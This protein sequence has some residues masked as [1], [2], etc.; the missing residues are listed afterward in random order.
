MSDNTPPIDYPEVLE[1]IGVIEV[2]RKDEEDE[3]VENFNDLAVDSRED[4]PGTDRETHQRVTGT[5]GTTRHEISVSGLLDEVLEAVYFRGNSST[6]DL[7]R[8]V[9]YGVIDQEGFE[10]KLQE[11]RDDDIDYIG[12]QYQSAGEVLIEEIV[13]TLSDL[14]ADELEVGIFTK[15]RESWNTGRLSL[16]HPSFW[17]FDFSESSLDSLEDF[18]NEDDLFWYGIDDIHVSNL[19]EEIQQYGD[20]ERYVFPG[21]RKFESSVGSFRFRSILTNFHSEGTGSR[22]S[23]DGDPIGSMYTRQGYSGL[24]MIFEKLMWCLYGYY[25]FHNEKD[26]EHEQLLE[27]SVDYEAQYGLLKGLQEGRQE[28]K[29]NWRQISRQ[30]DSIQH[31][32]EESEPF[33]KRT[34]FIATLV[35]S[36]SEVED[37]AKEEYEDLVEKYNDSIELVRS[38]IELNSTIETVDLQNKIRSQNESTKSLQKIGGILTLVI[39]VSSAISLAIQ[40]GWI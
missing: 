12:H 1:A 29:E 35:D 9:M 17:S 27:D 28:M 26:P 16:Y 2:I 38:N 18:M 32:F 4:L 25:N 37:Y 24:S 3:F 39:A 8:C 19:S 7:V 6:N 15:N 22:Y 21:R 13:E 40:A 36:A 5:T 23:R 11:K 20:K 34:G 30:S 14:I 31:S 33:G 10:E